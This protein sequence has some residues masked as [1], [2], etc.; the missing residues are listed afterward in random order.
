MTLWIG[1][2]LRRRSRRLYTI[3]KVSLT[4]KNLRTLKHDKS[5]LQAIEGFLLTSENYTKV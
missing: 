5:V 2:R 4:L 3:T 1:N